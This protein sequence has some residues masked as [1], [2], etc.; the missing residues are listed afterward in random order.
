MLQNEKIFCHLWKIFVVQLGQDQKATVRSF[1]V[2]WEY[3]VLLERATQNSKTQRALNL[4]TQTQLNSSLKKTWK[5][6]ITQA[7]TRYMLKLD[8]LKLIETI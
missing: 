3:L 6:R 4:K 2:C 1:K 8:S 7:K 5:T